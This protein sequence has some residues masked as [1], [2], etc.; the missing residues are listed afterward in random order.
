MGSAPGIS[1]AAHGGL[2]RHLAWRRH[3][4]HGKNN[5][6]NGGKKKKKQM[7]LAGVSVGVWR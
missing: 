3:L 5:A 4:R 1:V 2:A 7:L 6:M